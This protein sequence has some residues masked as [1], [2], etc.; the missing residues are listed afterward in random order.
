[1]GSE[2]RRDRRISVKLEVY[3]D[4]GY[5]QQLVQIAD[6][7]LGGCFIKALDHPVVGTEINLELRLPTGQW[8][9]LEGIVAHRHPGEGFGV[10]FTSQEKSH[11]AKFIEALQPLGKTLTPPPNSEDD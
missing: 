8:I 10:Q 6:L 7:S 1:M 9:F 4:K 2:Q 5:G 3:L 11:L